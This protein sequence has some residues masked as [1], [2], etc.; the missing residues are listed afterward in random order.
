MEAAE[1]PSHERK[2]ALLLAVSD[3]AGEAAEAARC[4]S[5]VPSATC[6]TFFWSPA[7][8]SVARPVSM[9]GP[10]VGSCGCVMT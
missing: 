6:V 7:R 2:L 4:F 3:G 9:A 8:L 10:S 1:L 5:G